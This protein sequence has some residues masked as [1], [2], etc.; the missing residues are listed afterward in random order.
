MKFKMNNR[1]WEIVETPSE[2]L[3]AEY[4]KEYENQLC[5]YNNET[6]TLCALR[7]RFKRKGISNPTQE[8][9]KYL[10]NK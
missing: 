1:N 3:L 6:L 4:K 10:L 2:W 5:F 9:K 8:A 7:T